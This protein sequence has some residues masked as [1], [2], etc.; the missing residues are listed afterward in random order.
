M[1]FGAS[2]FAPSFEKGGLG[3]ILSFAEGF[4]KDKST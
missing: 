3:W 4:M 2:S 1:I